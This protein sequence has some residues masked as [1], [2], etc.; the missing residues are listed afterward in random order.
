[1]RRYD[2][3]VADDAAS[4]DDDDDDVHIDVPTRWRVGDLLM[5]THSALSKT[6]TRTER[7]IGSEFPDDPDV[8]EALDSGEDTFAKVVALAAERTQQV[9]RMLTRT[10]A[11]VKQLQLSDEEQRRGESRAAGETGSQVRELKTTLDAMQKE[12]TLVLAQLQEQVRAHREM[13]AAMDEQNQEL[14]RAQIAIAMKSDEMRARS[15]EFD[16]RLL[17]AQRALDT[18]QQSVSTWRD[19]SQAS[20]KSLAAAEQR[21]TELEKKVQTQAE[22][23]VKHE[24]V[25][26]AKIQEDKHKDKLKDSEIQRLRADL[27]ASTQALAESDERRAKRSES[28]EHQKAAFAKER[29]ELL[30]KLEHADETVRELQTRLTSE[31]QSKRQFENDNKDLSRL[32]MEMKDRVR[33][34]M[35]AAPASPPAEPKA[36]DGGAMLKKATS[37]AISLRAFSRKRGSK[38][39]RNSVTKPQ[40]DDDLSTSSD[41]DSDSEIEHEEQELNAAVQQVVTS[42]FPQHRRA[43]DQSDEHITQNIALYED[44]KATPLESAA[45]SRKQSQD[46]LLLAASPP[47]TPS[48]S[49]S[50]PMNEVERMKLA[51]DEELARMKRQYVA[52][53]LEYKRLIIEQYERRQSQIHE[54]HRIEIENLIMLVQEKFKREIE[55]H[56]EKMLRAKESLKLLYRAMKVDSTAAFDRPAS[57][58]SDTGATDP[59]EEPVPLKSLL[60]AAVFAMSNSSKRS[61]VA[62]TEIKQIYETVKKSRDSVGGYSAARRAAPNPPAMSP[63]KIVVQTAKATALIPEEPR[64]ASRE[65]PPVLLFHVGCQ[66]CDEDFSLLNFGKGFR[67]SS[68]APERMDDFVLSSASLLS[69]NQSGRHGK[70]RVQ[71]PLRYERE[72]SSADTA[73]SSGFMLHL[74]EGA[75]FSDEIVAE[76]RELLPTLPA[77]S[78]YL[79]SALKQKLLLELLR[80]YSAWDARHFHHLPTIGAPGSGGSTNSG[81]EVLVGSPRDTPFMRRKALESVQRQQMHRRQMLATGGESIVQSSSSSSS[82]SASYSYTGGTVAWPSPRSLRVSPQPPL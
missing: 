46:L 60:R 59:G 8:V 51:C 79:S 67:G 2:E 10:I 9:Q 52:S 62:N 44:P 14:K 42:V 80:F 32:V 41:D 7:T 20:A 74:V 15:D 66:V 13:L 36:P 68:V 58:G 34:A 48:S 70:R 72:S 18:S 78:Y 4:H 26:Q 71:K 56:G 35:S 23:I 3:S 82:S 11:M 64:P 33:Q 17:E 75:A 76:L 81:A 16:R 54:H 53:L 39:K 73:A 57:S 37:F 24:V 61:S 31:R 45:T 38:M 30:S 43:L 28:S 21:V 22:E 77:G 69:G 5:A 40:P 63:S 25:L 49:S 27:A 55:K 65:A 19:K 50:A 29:Q 12:K 1:M 6:G 47:S